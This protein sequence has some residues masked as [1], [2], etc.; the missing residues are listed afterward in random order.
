[1]TCPDFILKIKKNT[2]DCYFI[3]LN[4]LRN[5]SDIKIFFPDKTLKL[6]IFNRRVHLLPPSTQRIRCSVH[7]APLARLACVF[8]ALRLFFVLLCLNTGVPEMIKKFLFS[9][10]FIF[11][12]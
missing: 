12:Q 9:A 8:A 4:K 3:R 10:L 6:K 5:Y 2:P 11:A 7:S 1:M